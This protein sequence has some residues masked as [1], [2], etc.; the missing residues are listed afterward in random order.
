ME[1]HAAKVWA[2]D[3]NLDLAA[4]HCCHLI[5]ARDLLE[6]FRRTRTRGADTHDE[7]LVNEAT[8]E[9]MRTGN[10]CVSSWDASQAWLGG[11]TRRKKG[12]P[13]RADRLAE[14]TRPQLGRGHGPFGAQTVRYRGDPSGEPGTLS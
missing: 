8:F 13:P 14:P 5:R 3:G 10:R 11:R 4:L 9:R 12:V 1:A 7:Q 2:H 6:R